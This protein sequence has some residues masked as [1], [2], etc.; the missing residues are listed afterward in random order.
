MSNLRYWSFPVADA[1]AA[2]MMT[3][4]SHTEVALVDMT[5]LPHFLEQLER[6]RPLPAPAPA[7]AEEKPATRRAAAKAARKGLT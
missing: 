1:K 3:T 6:I 5:A 2:V 4:S 7:A